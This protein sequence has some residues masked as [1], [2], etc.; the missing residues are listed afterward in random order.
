MWLEL[1]MYLLTVIEERVKDIIAN[2]LESYHGENWIIKGLPKNTYKTAKKMADDKN[3]ELLSNDE[4]AEIDTWDCITLADCREIVTYS[5]NWSEI[6]ESIV[7]RPEDVGLSNKEQKT[8][9]MST[10]SKEINKISKTTYSVPKVTFELISSI[11][12]WL[13]VK[14]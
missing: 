1:S 6:F 5:H 4:E 14:K 2:A 12:D 9:W 11:Y 7:T 3:Y 8:E 13:V 10:M